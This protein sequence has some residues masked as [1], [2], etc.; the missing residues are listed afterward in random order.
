MT[1]E[2]IFL[3]AFIVL[4]LSCVLYLLLYIRLGYNLHFKKHHPGMCRQV[5]GVEFGSEDFQVTS[6]GVA[7]ITS[8]V[9]HEAMSPQFKDFITQNQ[10]RGK[11]L[12]YDFNRPDQGVTELKIESDK[13]LNIK[14]FRPHGISLVEDKAKSEHLVYVINHQGS[15]QDRVEKFRFQPVT[16]TLVHLKSFTGDI[17]RVTHD[18][19]VVQEDQFYVSNYLYFSTYA[20]SVVE[21]LTPVGLG[22][23]VYFNGTHFETVVSSVLGPNGLTLS[24]DGR[25]LYVAYPLSERIEVYKRLSNNRLHM[26]QSSMVYTCPDNVHLS[27]SGSELYV[28]AHP[29]PYRAL[30]HLNQPEHVSPSS[31]LRIPLKNG[32]LVEDGVTELFYDHGDLI[33][34]SSVAAVYN[35]Q[36]LIGSIMNKLVFN[37]IH[38]L[39]LVMLKSALVAALAIFFYFIASIIW[40]LEFH[41]HYKKH[42]PGQCRQVKGQDFGAEDFQVTSDGL[43]FITSGFYIDSAAPEYKIFL[44]ENKIKGKIL[45]FDFN[46]PE[47]GAVELEIKSSGQFNKETFGPHG[48]S[49]LEDKVKSE[50]IL[51]VVN[52]QPSQPD[53]VEKFKYEPKTKQLVHL[54]YFT[55]DLFQQTNDLA[56]I[57]EDKFYISNYQYFNSTALNAIEALSNLPLCSIVFYN[58]SHYEI[59]VPQLISPNGVALSK[60]LR[61]LYVNFPLLKQVQ[62]FER[63]KDNSLTLVQKLNLRSA[64]DNPLLSSSG[65]GL[66]IGS[67]PI[68]HRIFAHLSD[69]RNKAPSSVLYVPLTDDGK[70]AGED[71]VIEL[72]YD[73]GDL[74]K[75][76]TVAYLYYNK[77]LIGSVID[78]LVICDLSGPVL[79]ADA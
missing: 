43:A 26:V 76:S 52:H 40:S 79:P 50:H 15:E 41:L 10:I 21:H 20:L 6:D 63:N 19:A 4:L 13:Q 59:S 23:I 48:V 60:D 42:Y 49:L 28:G 8:G 34:G 31:V 38:H 30:D 12:I 1:L 14:R 69:P 17:L 35:G 3:K 45:L 5:K 68:G 27:P 51:Y 65:K 70:F 24:A 61:Y 55:S 77:L 18:L 78:K 54:K 11:I 16:K 22:S 64:V 58:G 37:P 32:H 7:F 9:M 33:A 36:L 2:R 56:V 57:E 46:Q 75:A 53:R 44:K 66:F 71:D 39:Q 47:Q 67:H 62:A 25:L 29:V 73:H 72:F 74:I